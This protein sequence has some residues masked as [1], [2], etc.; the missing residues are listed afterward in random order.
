MSIARNNFNY[1]EKEQRTLIAGWYKV[2][3]TEIT[4]TKETKN[5]DATGFF[6]RMNVRVRNDIQERD[7]WLS[8]DHPS[9]FVVTKSHNIGHMLRMMFPVITDDADYVGQSFWL[10]FKHYIDKKTGEKKES[11]FDYKR[12]VSLDGKETLD[13]QPV[14]AST[15]PTPPPTSKANNWKPAPV[16]SD[17][18][19]EVPF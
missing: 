4:E 3:I 13:G 12:N 9:D 19:D 7:V 10:H 15:A 17:S 8:F 18:D 6:I 16:D 5:G 1:E 14:D 2:T 11:F